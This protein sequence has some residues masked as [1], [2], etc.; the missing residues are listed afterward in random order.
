MDLGQGLGHPHAGRVQRPPLIIV[1]D[2][3]HRRAIV[4][5]YRVG[6]IDHGGGRRDGGGGLGRDVRDIAGRLGA[7]NEEPAE[8]LA[9]IAR[10]PRTFFRIRTFAWLSASVTGLARSRR[11]WLSQ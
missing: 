2:P 8:A 4:E 11:K 6:G 7:S 3:T 9:W 10:R 1:E 5:D